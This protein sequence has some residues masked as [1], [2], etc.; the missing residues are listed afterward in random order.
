MS[1]RCRVEIR[2][3]PRLMKDLRLLHRLGIWGSTP[4]KV[5]RNLLLRQIQDLIA[6]KM[7]PL[8]YP[9]EQSQPRP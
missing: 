5:A 9:D 6:A 8:Q 7:L 3:N 1:K 2:L 4:A